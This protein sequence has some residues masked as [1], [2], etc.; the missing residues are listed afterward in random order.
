MSSKYFEVTITPDAGKTFDLSELTFTFQRS[1]TGVRQ[2]A[3][4]SSKD[5][6]TNNLTASI[7]PENAA[8]SIV[9]T[10]VF[11]V[12]DASSSA[13]NGPTITLG[14]A[15]KGISTPITFRFYGFNTESTNGTFS[16]DNVKFE[17]KTN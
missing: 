12:T 8:L 5:G 16:I 7:N 3:V 2:C 15:F 1:S 9:A 13:N 17:G 4:R 10:N 11:Q 14:T 6:F